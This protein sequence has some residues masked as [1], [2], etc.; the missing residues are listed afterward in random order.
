M[1]KKQQLSSEM[2]AKYQRNF[3]VNKDTA[4]ISRAVMK[5]GIKASRENPAV[6]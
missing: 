4:V 6:S 1:E 3:A 5:N 2:I